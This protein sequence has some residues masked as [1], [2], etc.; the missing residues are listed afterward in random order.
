MKTL[1]KFATL[2][3]SILLLVSMAACSAFNNPGNNDDDTDDDTPP[4]TQVITVYK[5]D[6]PTTYTVTLGEVAEIDVFTKPGYYFNGAY[7]SAVGGTKYF[8]DNGLSTMVWGAGNPSTYYARFD[9]IYNINYYE[10]QYEENPYA[11]STSGNASYIDFEFSN[12]LK[13]AIS[14]N[15][16]KEL[17]VTISLSLSNNSKDWNF[18]AV[19]ITNLKSGGELTI[20]EEEIP[21]RANVYTNHVYTTTLSTRLLQ[22]GKIYIYLYN[23][24]TIWSNVRYY[25][26]NISVQIQFVNA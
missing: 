26:K 18:G 15:L 7:D 8:D 4:Q 14:Q 21:N 23:G 13:R 19:G 12:E 24:Y 17:R 25:A 5:D 22:N 16:D 6:T 20:F 10:L 2:L 3:L 11:M 9:S 1:T